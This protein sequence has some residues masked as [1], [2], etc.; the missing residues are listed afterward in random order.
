[1]IVRG[2]DIGPGVEQLSDDRAD[3]TMR[4]PVECGRAVAVSAVRVCVPGQES[5][6]GAHVA[7]PRRGNEFQTI[8]GCLGV[9]R[10]WY[11]PYS[12]CHREAQQWRDG[13]QPCAALIKRLAR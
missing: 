10:R 5:A 2:V 13:S 1:V 9:R 4:G 3:V 6:H 8:R 7:L 11:E 12:E